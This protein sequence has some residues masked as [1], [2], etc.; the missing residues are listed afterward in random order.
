MKI[1]LIPLL[2]FLGIIITYST[3][4]EKNDAPNPETAIELSCADT[5]TC[6][7]IAAG[8]CTFSPSSSCRIEFCSGTVESEPFNHKPDN[9]TLYNNPVQTPESLK[10][11]TQYYQT[12]FIIAC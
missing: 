4:I 9:I 3:F 12:A 10:T 1:S 11:R 8:G 2:F 5:D 7:C 6:T